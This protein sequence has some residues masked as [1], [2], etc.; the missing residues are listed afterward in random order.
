MTI[1]AIPDD[2]T[3][4]RHRAGHEMAWGRA[5]LVALS[6]HAGALLAMTATD[7]ARQTPAMPEP[8]AVSILFGADATDLLGGGDPAS[9]STVPTSP[10]L[11]AAAAAA[12]PDT[13]VPAAW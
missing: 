12:V 10:A 9:P 13:A 6:M 3:P 1:R 2:L 8:R 11:V 4:A 5:V 7:V